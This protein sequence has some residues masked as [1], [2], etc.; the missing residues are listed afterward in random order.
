MF[1]VKHQGWVEDAKDIGL[2][3]TEAQWHALERYASLLLEVALPR[4]MVAV[5]DRERLWERHILDGLR[6]AHSLPEGAH[7][8]DIGSGAG[9]PGVPLAIVRPDTSV[10]LIEPRR[11]RVAFLEAVV[12][13][14]RLANAVVFLGKASDVEGRFDV[15]TARA[16]ASPTRSWAMARP[17]LGEVG[18]L[19][20]WAGKG[21]DVE[22]VRDIGVSC[23]L[24]TRS[25]LAD[26]GPL[27]I[28]APQ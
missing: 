28:M 6:A 8:A 13:D 1:H 12:A 9:I 26:E 16:L 23:R 11:S 25:G 19:I 10:V 20:Y 5:G 7:I 2:E 22:E 24:S 15:A 4:G 14:L 21:F 3:P 17:L 18:S 27:V